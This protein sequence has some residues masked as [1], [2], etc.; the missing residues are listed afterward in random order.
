VSDD[1][2]P[3]GRHV[4]FAGA[5]GAR[6]A[7]RLDLPA[8]EPRA[9]VLFAH[10]FTC[11]KDLRSVGRIGRALAERGIAV[12]RFDFTGIGQ[13]EGDFADTTFSSNVADLEAA[14]DFMRAELAAPRLLVGHSL[15]GA[16]VLAVAARVPEVAAVATIAAPANTDQFRARLLRRVPELESRGEGEIS[17]GG[18]RY[19]IR[20]ELLDD[21]AE[22]RLDEV[23]DHLDK[24]L[25]VLHS[26][27]DATVDITQG[28]RL[29]ARA[30]QPKS[31][32]AL[33]GAD[34][35]L[36]DNPADAAFVGEL[37]ATWAG[38]YLP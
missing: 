38:R 18:G 16:A 31:F 21:L 32:V 34:H 11:G 36:L 2:P 30:R 7:A 20:R 4:R 1:T 6:L 14:V 24:P 3:A 10:C 23:L 5:S 9:W 25:L 28:E 35:L 33:D 37:L 19:R 12:M 13:S 26:P 17:L 15:G 22:Q 29:F 27:A 8:G